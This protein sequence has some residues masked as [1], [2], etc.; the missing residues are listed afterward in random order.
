[1]QRR[2]LLRL[3]VLASVWSAV[4]RLSWAAAQPLRRI[5]FGS[6]L[7]Q[8][9][10]MGILD[11]IRAQRPDLML[12]I[13]DN[14]YG[15]VRDDD[16]ACL[17]LQR[18]YDQ[19]GAQPSFRALRRS[20]AMLATWDDHDYGR[21]DGGVDWAFKEKARQRFLEFW[22]VPRTDPRRVRDGVYTSAVF[23]PA[24]QRVQVIL[25]DTRYNRSALKPTDLRGVAG[26][27]RY[28]PDDDPAK[29][30]LGAA[31]WAWLARVIQQPAEVRV[32]A[33]SIQVLADG[34]G[35]ERWGNLPH[36]KQRLLDL[37]RTAS[38]TTVLLSGDRHLGGLYQDHGVYDLTSSSLN[39]PFGDN[40]AEAGSNR[41]GDVFTA[42]NFGQVTLDWAGKTI[43]L[44]LC[45]SLGHSVRTQTVAIA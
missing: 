4:P 9:R 26:R 24:G 7:D 6:C 39:K 25:L 10:D 15:D 18:A 2:Q 29:T 45:N 22:R 31:Q 11:V 27:E 28:L 14:V 37:I 33:S 36:E 40:S 1:M 30:F 21:N 17:A 41:V 35:W 38:G 32:I 12:M 16:P 8:R 44:D 19:L 5:V 34:H 42:A 13:G 3:G 20:V 23:G 43:T